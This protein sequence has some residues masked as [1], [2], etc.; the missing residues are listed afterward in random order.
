[1]V[2]STNVATAKRFYEIADGRATGDLTE[3]FTED[4]QI[5]VPKFGA[6]TGHEAMIAAG[7]GRAQFRRMAH[8]ADEFEIVEHDDRVIVEGTTEGETV[9]G[10]TWDG[11][12]TVPGHFCAVFDFRD[13]RI[14]R[15]HVY[16]DPDLGHED[17][18]RYPW[19]YQPSAETVNS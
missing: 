10:R 3:L 4:V 13:G 15:M 2:D 19:W 17:T 1:M 12:E 9:T 5:Y 18:A 11:R 7:K 14:C 6:G 8:H 16:F